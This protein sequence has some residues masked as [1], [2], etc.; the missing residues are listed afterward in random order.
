MK[1][2]EGSKILET[3]SNDN[4]IFRIKD[5]SGKN[6]ADVAK[7]DLYFVIPKG[8]L[9]ISTSYG[10]EIQDSSF[11]KMN[12]IGFFLVLVNTLKKDFYEYRSGVGV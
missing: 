1:N 4:W 9:D 2:N 8:N 5:L 6:I 12:L 7:V 11:N 3:E 10:L